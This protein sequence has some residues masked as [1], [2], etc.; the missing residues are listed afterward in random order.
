M[1]LALAALLSSATLL[2]PGPRPLLQ[3]AYFVP[4]D[5]QPIPGYVERIDRIMQEVREFYA[6]GMAAHG[7]GRLTFD[8]A[9]DAAG[10]LLVHRVDAHG[11]AASYGRNAAGQVAAEVRPVL[12]AAGLDPQRTHVIIFQ[13]LLDWQ[14]GKALEVGPYVGGGSATSGTCWVYDDPR[15]DPAK[16]SS[17]EPG[18]YYMRPCSLGEFNSH[19]LGGVAHELGHALGL[20]H[21]KEPG[22]GRA[23]PRSLMG[24][25]NHSYGEEQRG[26][27]P[28]SVLS[29]A[30]AWPLAKHPLFTGQPAPT[31]AA[32]CELQ[33]V[34]FSQEAG[35]V[36]LRG[37]LAARPAAYG[38]VAYQDPVTPAADYDAVSW[39]APVAADGRFEVGVGEFKPGPTQI[40]LRACLTDGSASYQRWDLTVDAAGRPDLAPLRRTQLLAPAVVAFARSDAAA[41]RTAAATAR[42]AAPQ[43]A[44]LGRRLDLLQRLLQPVPPVALA[45]LP[46]TT[47]TVALSTVAWADART[48]WGPPLRDQVP[49]E[50]GEPFL[51]L[52]GTVCERGLYAHAPARHE[53]RLGG[54]WR[55]LATGYGL[56]DGAGGS[57]VFVIRGDGRELFR[58]AK[59]S[60]HMRREATVELAG[61]QRLELLVEDAGD[62]NSSD[63][64]IW[65]EPL[66]SR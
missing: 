24:A 38:V 10:K 33:A 34:E 28:G 15:L 23:V 64:G 57:V 44:E 62:G 7:F 48:G 25:G 18:G 47:T 51:S 40:R 11:P 39:A 30:S 60:D 5:R 43:D 13:V 55:R 63:W 58:S 52:G 37:R 3:V 66:L 61:V 16:L 42:A 41:L 36:V 21:D 29:A 45:T 27:G 53:V 56:E 2:A 8:L 1:S 6:R 12:Q 14:D 46:A 17:K 4:A 65:V 20:P 35:Q 26:E 19:Y 50:R 54:A 9:R 32:N 22:A 31:S 59:V 49:T